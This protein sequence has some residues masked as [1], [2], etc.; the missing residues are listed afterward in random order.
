MKN[1]KEELGKK[2]TARIKAMSD[3]E[4]FDELKY[5]VNQARS[6]PFYDR[7]LAQAIGTECRSRGW[8]KHLRIPASWEI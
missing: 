7:K 3:D 6:K 1:E 4:L 5:I 2:L 8:L